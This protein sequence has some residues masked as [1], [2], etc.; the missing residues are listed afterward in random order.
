MEEKKQKKKENVDMKLWQK[1][2]KNLNELRSQKWTKRTK[3][4]CR[5]CS[6]T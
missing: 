3:K 1:H 5:L 2:P 6:N 4:K